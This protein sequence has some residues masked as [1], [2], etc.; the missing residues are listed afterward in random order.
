[1]DPSTGGQRQQSTTRWR[2]A[3][4]E[5]VLEDVSQDR[6]V[7]GF[8]PGP[9][10][11]ELYNV[12]GDGEVPLRNPHNSHVG[13]L[14]RTG[15]VG[16][17]L[18]SLLWIAWLVEVG[19]LR[20]RLIRNGRSGEAAV[21]GWLIVSVAAILVNAIFDPTLEG[22]QVGWWLWAFLGFGIGMSVLDRWNRLPALDLGR[23]KQVARS[24]VVTAP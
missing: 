1:V 20:K 9:D 15:I 21:A 13:V 19:S 16:A 12:S 10:L 8:G 22:P 18:W 14:A 7:G 11:G 2:L 4:W 5:Q 23:G 24:A 6:P 3:I 17:A